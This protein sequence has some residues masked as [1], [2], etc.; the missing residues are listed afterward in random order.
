MPWMQVRIMRRDNNFSLY[1]SLK[2]GVQIIHQGRLY[3]G[4]YIYIVL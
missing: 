1:L 2:S 3:V 4:D